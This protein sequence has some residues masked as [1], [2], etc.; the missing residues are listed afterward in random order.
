MNNMKRHNKAFTASIS[1]AVLCSFL[2]CNSGIKKK[3]M[4]F[5]KITKKEIISQFKA[6]PDA[7]INLLE[8]SKHFEKY[9][10]RWNEAFRFLI[11]SDLKN[12]SVGR[13]DL[14]E[15]VYVTVSE[16]ETKNPEDAKFESHRK[17]IDLQY[18]LEGEELI[19]HTNP[20]DLEII[21]PYSEEKDIAFYEYDGGEILKA[22][23]SNYFIFFPDDAHRPCLHP[24]KKNTV[25]KIV[26]KIKY[27]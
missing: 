14:N 13:I 8:A 24:G 16:Y 1:L 12:L 5:V 19:G 10:E 21:S 4:E 20:H 9:P 22:S 27:D 17:Y 2:A 7:S 3:N 25:R 15:N 6:K 23:A 11:E 18:L 26:V